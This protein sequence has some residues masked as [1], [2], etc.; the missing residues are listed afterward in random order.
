VRL[1]IA[2]RHL[3]R[4]RMVYQP[5]TFKGG[6]PT[7]EK[8]AAALFALAATSPEP[9]PFRDFTKRIGDMIT[10]T[11][12]KPA[13]ARHS[14]VGI[15]R[16]CAIVAFSCMAPFS[17][18]WAASTIFTGN[19]DSGSLPSGMS[20]S[21][22][23]DTS[24]MTLSFPSSPT[25]AGTHSAKFTLNVPNQT[26]PILRNEIQRL[27]LGAIGGE[28]IY[29]FSHFV[30]SDWPTTALPVEVTQFWEKGDSGEAG[31]PP[32]LEFT[33]AD[34]IMRITS[35]SD[36]RPIFSGV[37]NVQTVVYSQ[38]VG[39]NKWVD[40]R[41][42]VRWSWGD[43]SKPAGYL[44]IHKNYVK[45]VDRTGPNCYNNTPTAAPIR[46]KAGIYTRS[47]W[48]HGKSFPPEAYTFYLDEITAVKK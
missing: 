15:I 4:G 48:A 13:K 23:G 34:G 38:S 19:F 1:V 26:F 47:T 2:I 29:T 45:V 39:R 36:S 7:D 22:E 17:L 5:V 46:I 31:Q 43:T 40:W 12:E 18:A 11:E 24:K 37:P 35:R 8:S 41:V 25:R 32:P 6:L 21:V 10:L 33:I 44:R 27:D 16:A 42:E 30:P 9:I 20:T 3:G 14:G 28:Y